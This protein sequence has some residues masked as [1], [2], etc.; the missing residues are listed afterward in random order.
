VMQRAFLALLT[1]FTC[2]V[3]AREQHVLSLNSFRTE[4]VSPPHHQPWSLRLSQKTLTSE[5]TLLLSPEA[6]QVHRQIRNPGDVLVINKSITT[7]IDESEPDD[8]DILEIIGFDE[9]VLWD[10]ADEICATIYLDSP[11]TDTF[12]EYEVVLHSK[13]TSLITKRKLHY[14]GDPANRIDFV[15]MFLP[16]AQS[17]RLGVTDTQ[18][19]NARNSTTT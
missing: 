3:N 16:R 14:S 4:S 1:T 13:M 18:S 10:K 17:L 9:Q 8:E 2:L 6:A 19:P 12:A 7:N 5:C 15:I 11:T